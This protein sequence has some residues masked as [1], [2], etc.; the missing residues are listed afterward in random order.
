MNEESSAYMAAMT[1]VT[2]FIEEHIL[3]SAVGFQ[4]AIIFIALSIGYIASLLLIKASKV[5]VKELTGRSF[6]SKVEKY[7][8]NI[9][10]L[11]ALPWPLISGTILWVIYKSAP[12]PEIA[13]VKVTTEAIR[14]AS[15]LLLA[16]ALIRFIAVFIKSSRLS[17]IFVILAWT[18]AALTAVGWLSPVIKALD[19]VGI[20]TGD[21]TLSIWRLFWMIILLSLCF[22]L[23][24]KLILF[25]QKQIN[26]TTSL[27]PSLRVLSSKVSSFVLYI[28]AG[29]LALSLVGIDITA[30]AVFTGALGVGIGFGLQKIISNFIS[31]IILLMDKSLKPGDV[32][33]VE[34][35]SGITYGWVEKLG[36][37]YTSITTRDGTET[38]IPN[39][40]FIT[41]AVTN[42]SFS[43]SRIRRKL[44]VGIAYHSDVEKAMALC[45]E[46]AK[47][48][49][50]VLVE[51]ETVCQLRDFGDSSVNLEIRF[52]IADPAD[53]VKNVESDIN[54]AIWKLFREHN[55]DIPFPQRDLHL[56][57]TGDTPVTL[58]V[59]RS[60]KTPETD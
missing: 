48:V 41:N 13:G 42:W 35:G 15:V 31:G 7:K 44:P 17:R 58:T 26:Q 22:W 49:K 47:S 32:I 60:E 21:T 5:L 8:Y 45:V 50:R 2:T 19:S 52:W 39:E 27:D 53:G 3:T 55:I 1:N 28:A 43:N 12:L 11:K 30:F 51:P 34:T 24:N 10:A 23:A 4:L 6:F 37:R 38:L 20:P 18:T 29:L 33:E 36:L 25:V 9:S 57:T 16:F 59:N 46:A 40:I 14:L 56:K 54:L